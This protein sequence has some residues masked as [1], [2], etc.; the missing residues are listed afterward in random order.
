MIGDYV[1]K[2]GFNDKE[3]VIEL[4][5]SLEEPNMVISYFHKIIIY[6]FVR[7][8]TFISIET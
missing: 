1:D 7:K 8:Y 4:P 5:A 6:A 3:I 2:L